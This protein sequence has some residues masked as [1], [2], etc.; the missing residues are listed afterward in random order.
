MPFQPHELSTIA[1]TSSTSVCH[2]RWRISLI[3]LVTGHLR[4]QRPTP[5]ASVRRGRGHRRRGRRHGT[6][7]H[8][9]PGRRRLD[10]HRGVQ[11]HRRQDRV[12]VVGVRRTR[13]GLQV[14]LDGFDVRATHELFQRLRRHQARGDGTDLL[15]LHAR[16]DD[17]AR[18]GVAVRGRGVGHPDAGDGRVL[19]PVGRLQPRLGVGHLLGQ[20]LGGAEQVQ[21]ERRVVELDR[22]EDR[23][24]VL[25]AQFGRLLVPKPAAGLDR[26]T[27]ELHR[28]GE[29][30]DRRDG[31]HRSVRRVIDLVDVRRGCRKDVQRG[32][33]TVQ[34]IRLQQ[35][36]RRG[37]QV[38]D[39]VGQHP[40][41]LVEP[42][43][44]GGEQA[45]E[46]LDRVGQVGVVM[47]EPGGEVGQVLVE[48]DELRVVLVQRVDEQRQA[49][50]HGEEVAA[51]LVQCGQRLRQVAQRGV[52]LLALAGQPVGERL[53]DLTERALRLLGGGTQLRDDVGDAVAQLVP[54]DRNLGALFGDHGVIGQHRTALVRRLQLDGAR[55]HQG[56]VEDHRR[57]VGRHPVFVLVVEGDLHLVAGGLDLVDRTHPQAHDLDLVPRVQSV[58]RREVGHHGVVGQLLV[59]PPADVADDEGQ[60]DHQ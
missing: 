48:R 37:L 59:E 18:L 55:G 53:D 56:G 19:V 58:G 29:V 44:H 42:G 49:A 25:R 8:A 28:V 20:C 51:A 43:A 40:G 22:V 10:R 38:V 45:V 3:A 50:H 31:D 27:D 24:Q 39:V 30:G 17:P 6:R 5:A 16:G 9:R 12:L 15:T 32:L 54:F 4:S 21:A 36:V 34:R 7:G 52:E 41:V 1:A 11:S 23:R 14:R 46:L 26:A 35:R 47:R 60:H 57:R 13:R 33:Q 2:A